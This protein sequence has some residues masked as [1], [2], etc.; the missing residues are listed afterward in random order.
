[1]SRTLVFSSA[2]FLLRLEACCS[3][4]TNCVPV[5]WGHALQNHEEC[6]NFKDTME[7]PF[8]HDISVLLSIIFERGCKRLVLTL[9]K[10]GPVARCP[11]VR[12]NLESVGESDSLTCNQTVPGRLHTLCAWFEENFK[13]NLLENERML[14]IL[15]VL[16]DNEELLLDLTNATNPENNSVSRLLFDQG[17]VD[18]RFV[19]DCVDPTSTVHLIN[20]PAST[21]A[22]EIGCDVAVV[23]QKR[24]GVTVVM[25][26]IVDGTASDTFAN[27]LAG[28]HAWAQSVSAMPVIVVASLPAWLLPGDIQQI[29]EMLLKSPGADCCGWILEY[30]NNVKRFPLEIRNRDSGHVM[31]TT[32]SETIVVVATDDT[33]GV[34]SVDTVY[35]ETGGMRRYMVVDTD[36]MQ[37]SPTGQ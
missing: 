15:T 13:E 29:K 24:D 37:A 28:T 26:N 9:D 25:L 20:G 16:C 4:E 14:Y 6:R 18:A 8:S 2:D 32:N 31:Q 23:P 36:G 3:T 30:I 33:L 35:T 34:V 1:M 19:S 17:K 10:R 12:S 27:F 22:A 7:G 21:H 11:S 5:L